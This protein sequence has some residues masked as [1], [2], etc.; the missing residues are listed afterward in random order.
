MNLQPNT[1]G[2][3]DEV[4]AQKALKD[5]AALEQL[6][7]RYEAR[8][9]AYV[10][11]I[12]SFPQAEA[13]EVLQEAFLKVWTHLNNFDSSLSFSS[14]IYR[15]VHNETISQFRKKKSRGLNE[16]IPL[17]STLFEGGA[18][19]DLTQLVDQKMNA[20]W[21]QKVLSTLTGRYRDVLVLKYFEDQTYE[22]ISDILKVPPGTVATLLSRAK[23]QFKASYSKMTLIPMTPSP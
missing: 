14:W 10:R 15:I 2:L 22:E 12:S 6:L 7:K 21:V 17:E 23:A 3:S 4:L 11:R 8:L 13:E 9:L 16:Q 18:D 1:E 19:S 20:E 5:L